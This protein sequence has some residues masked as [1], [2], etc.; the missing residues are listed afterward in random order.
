ML[1][2]QKLES[3]Q[4]KLVLKFQN[5]LSIENRKP[6]EIFS[7]QQNLNP[8]FLIFKLKILV[9]NNLGYDNL[10]IYSTLKNL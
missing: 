10:L 3:N 1:I 5:S 8:I 6:I 4:K 2:D 9:C 7:L